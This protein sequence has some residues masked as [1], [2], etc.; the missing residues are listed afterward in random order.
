[1]DLYTKRTFLIDTENA[2][3]IGPHITALNAGIGY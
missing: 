2:F 3:K 1:M